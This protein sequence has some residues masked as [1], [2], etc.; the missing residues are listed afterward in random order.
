MQIEVYADGSAT[1]KEKPGG[2]GFVIVIDGVKAF[3]GSGPMVSA[4]NNDAELEASIQGLAAVLKMIVDNPSSFPLE[5]TVTLV[6]DSQIIL[7]WA[8]G[9][10]KFKQKSK[11]NKYDQLYYLVKKLKVKTRWVK[12]H[13]GDEHNERCDKLAND[14]RRQ[15]T[16]TQKQEEKKPKKG[17]IR[18]KRTGVLNVWYKG[19]L[20]I[21]DLDSGIIENYNKKEHGTRNSVIEVKEGK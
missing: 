9:S 13:S 11:I 2:Y 10:Y 18:T 8:D 6:S 7:G 21:I 5:R 15:L 17:N 3:E 4:S 12:G 14:A 20:K 19:V 1:V 16:N